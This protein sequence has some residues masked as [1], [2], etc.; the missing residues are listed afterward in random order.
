[1]AGASRFIKVS[2]ARAY[3]VRNG[4]LVPIY[5]GMAAII[6]E[7]AVGRPQIPEP[8]NGSHFVLTAGG[9]AISSEGAERPLEVSAARADVTGK[10]T[11]CCIAA[12]AVPEVGFSTAVSVGMAVGLVGGIIVS[13]V[14]K[15][16]ALVHGVAV[17][18][19]K[20]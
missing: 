20:P 3:V 16:T 11:G 5:A 1:M 8:T 17:K 19:S 18:V 14:E 13:R 4:G 10:I 7:T 12:I 9:I 2:S 6:P 15:P